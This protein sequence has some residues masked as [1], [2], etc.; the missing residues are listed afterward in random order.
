MEYATTAFDIREVKKIEGLGLIEGLAAGYDNVDHGG[1]KLIVGAMTKSL[2]ERGNVPVPMLLHHDLARPIGVWKSW[3]ERPEGLY[4]KGEMVLETRDAHE[5]FTLA[6]RGALRGLSIGYT[7]NN[8][9]Y[10]GKVR[11]LADVELHEVSLVTIGMNARAR[12]TT[13]KEIG[14]ARDIATILQGAGLSGRQAKVATGAAWRSINE[15]SDEAAGDAELAAL[16]Q[17]A[18]ARLAKGGR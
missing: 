4:V 15:Q 11:V 16:I 8:E 14:G 12:I 18:T 6:K 10:D 2:A 13:L 5:A 1:D 7:V 3:Q 9:R 17:S